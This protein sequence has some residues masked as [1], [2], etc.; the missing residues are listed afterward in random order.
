MFRE[1]DLWWSTLGRNLQFQAGTYSLRQ[2]LTVL[3]R[4][5]QF[6]GLAGTYSLRQ[7]LTVSTSNPG[8]K[9][10]SKEW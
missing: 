4:N 1:P 6:R 5:L 2:E 9:K 7:E 3:G 8:F 10:E